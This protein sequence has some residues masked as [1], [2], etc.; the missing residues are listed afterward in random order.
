MK[1]RPTIPF[2]IVMAL[3]FIVGAIFSALTRA[4]DKCEVDHTRVNEFV[5]HERGQCK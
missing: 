5:M 1:N 2:V 3:I 4:D